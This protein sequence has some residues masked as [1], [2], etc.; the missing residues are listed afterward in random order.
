MNE[1]K[2]WVTLIA[3]TYL[4]IVASACPASS[5][6]EFSKDGE[7]FKYVWRQYLDAQIVKMSQGREIKILALRSGLLQQKVSDKFLDL[8]KVV[9]LWQTS[10]DE[11]GHVGKNEL[12][13]DLATH[14]LEKYKLYLI[15]PA[16]MNA[17]MMSACGDS[18][19]QSHIFTAIPVRN[20]N[21]DFQNRLFYLRERKNN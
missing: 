18:F 3:S 21:S 17:R 7:S 12:V 11:D 4:A 9:G 15:P 10:L 6:Q 1:R 20:D 13:M 5:E 19:G 16:T 2:Q 8:R 14:V